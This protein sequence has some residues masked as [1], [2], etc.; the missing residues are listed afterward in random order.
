MDAKCERRPGFEGKISAQAR[1]HVQPIS[2]SRAA[3]TS[4]TSTNDSKMSADDARERN[5][6]ELPE[7]EVLPVRTMLEE[8]DVNVLAPLVRCSKRESA[9]ALAAELAAPAVR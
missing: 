3:V 6:D 2:K 4:A 1:R 9:A 7:P 8:F 5:G